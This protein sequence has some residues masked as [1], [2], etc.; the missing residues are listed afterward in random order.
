MS[1]RT[2]GGSLAG[3]M[4]PRPSDVAGF[5]KTFKERAQQFAQQQQQLAPGGA[6]RVAAGA[7][8]SGART[9]AVVPH[10]SGT[11]PAVGGAATPWFTDPHFDEVSDP[12]GVRRH[13]DSWT[14]SLGE[15]LDRNCFLLVVPEHQ[16]RKYVW[17]CKADNPTEPLTKLLEDIL[18][19]IHQD[20]AVYTLNNVMVMA[21][22][23]LSGSPE[24]PLQGDVV[25]GQ[26][27]TESLNVV[28]G[29]MSACMMD[30]LQT[31][32]PDPDPSSRASVR[33]GVLRARLACIAQRFVY[34]H[35]GNARPDTGDNLLRLMMQR[36]QEHE[37]EQEKLHKSL[38]LR[39]FG[40]NGPKHL[41]EM[42][43]SLSPNVIATNIREVYAWLSHMAGFRLSGQ[44]GLAIDR[45][46][47]LPGSRLE[48]LT[49]LERMAAFLQHMETRVSI[50]VNVLDGDSLGPLKYRAFVNINSSGVPVSETDRFMFG[51][52]CKAS[53]A[54]RR[55]HAAN[56]GSVRRLNP[57]GL[58][59]WF[60]WM[61]EHNLDE[62]RFK[63]VLRTM[64]YV[65]QADK[66]AG[67][68]AVEASFQTL[69]FYFLGEV[70]RDGDT[71]RWLDFSVMTRDKPK[72]CAASD[73]P[74]GLAQQL[75]RWHKVAWRLGELEKGSGPARASMAFL[76]GTDDDSVI[77]SYLALAL[78]FWLGGE[79][80]LEPA[81]TARFLNALR[82]LERF[83]VALRL[84]VPVGGV[85][86][87][88]REQRH[89][90]LAELAAALRPLDPEPA[91]S[92][93]E[94]EG[95]VARALALPNDGEILLRSLLHDPLYT[96][97]AGG[98]L[99]RL[100]LAAA[101]ADLSKDGS[102]TARLFLGSD[103]TVEHLLCQGWAASAGKQEWLNAGW[104]ESTAAFAMHRLG[105]LGPL[106][107]HWGTNDPEM[108]NINSALGDKPWAEK[109]MIMRALNVHNDSFRLT[110]TLL[111]CARDYNKDIMPPRPEWQPVLGF[112][113]WHLY[114]VGTLAERWDLSGAPLTAAL[115]AFIVDAVVP[116]SPEDLNTAAAKLGEEGRRALE[117]AARAALLPASPSAQ[118][119]GAG[120]ARPAT[121]PRA[122]APAGAS[123]SKPQINKLTAPL[124]RLG[125]G[126]LKALCEKLGI[127]PQ[128]S[129]T[130]SGPVPK[131]DII[132]S[133][134][135]EVT[136]ERRL[137]EARKELWAPTA[138]APDPV[139]SQPLPAAAAQPT[140]QQT[141]SLTAP[142]LPV[143]H[144]S[145]MPPVVP[146]SVM[147]PPVPAA[148]L[149][150]DNIPDD[151]N[152][153]DIDAGAGGGPSRADGAQKRQRCVPYSDDET[154]ALRDFLKE[155]SPLS[156][157]RISRTVFE[158]AVEQVPV[159]QG[160]T[161]AGLQKKWQDMMTEH[162]VHD[163][164][165][166]NVWKF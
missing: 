127:K 53:D 113:F 99:A 72:E 156:P 39:L 143:Q 12:H 105:N 98:Q 86:H 95:A 104:T 8:A 17:T 74:D 3:A 35:A 130:A 117:I 36:H 102:T 37:P 80:L 81:A 55:Q 38:V 63:H 21:E 152:E 124:H 159:L 68:P 165:W 31:Q 10:G 133:L 40:P 135:R 109:F 71:F 34:H 33:A 154:K 139:L 136:S 157:F 15:Y 166:G 5:I 45:R 122:A 155:K 147:P 50:V 149:A 91:G 2:A 20:D 92:Y 94:N 64:K 100:C 125:H 158:Q 84:T 121:A 19:S 65:V 162:S 90:R 28:Y 138:H 66:A 141:G 160:R 119:D 106:P 118:G 6:I 51:L 25:D 27:R 49:P 82:Q 56:D 32:D 111:D 146:A 116:F 110:S 131:T 42:L 164:M 126:D 93:A 107:R 115:R 23:V 13:Q 26:Q 134:Q 101:E 61:R 54:I 22:N 30:M 148:L 89:T 47:L 140:P 79:N 46:T 163:C 67:A 77:C 59:K 48:A 112:L 142:A 96:E 16:Q 43:K 83:V 60:T 151:G 132:A 144:A 129:G 70:G 128:R 150:A 75:L 57:V 85:N 114:L 24:P 7:G 145:A 69:Y 137:N 44:V 4:A 73:D 88:R 103:S 14:L 58:P 1:G 29:V 161:V 62:D 87:M 41:L 9:D 153:G 78:A 120:P 123:R 76:R 18:N 11:A 97:T 108:Q 52:S